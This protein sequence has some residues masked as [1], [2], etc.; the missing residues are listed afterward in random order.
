MRWRSIFL[1]SA[2]GIALLMGT[3]S[4]AAR[5]DAAP[6]CI[7]CS[8]ENCSV[9]CYCATGY[10]FVCRT[11]GINLPDRNCVTNAGLDP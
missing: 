8:N 6:S 11:N 7:G 4:V 9:Q 10:S 1:G 2:A 3:T 5:A